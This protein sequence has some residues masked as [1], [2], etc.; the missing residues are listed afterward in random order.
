MFVQH[1]G[2]ASHHRHRNDH[3]RRQ[4]S[5]EFQASPN[6][7]RDLGQIQPPAMDKRPPSRFFNFV[8]Q[9]KYDRKTNNNKNKKQFYYYYFLFFI[10]QYILYYI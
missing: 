7:G 6:H 10:L 5:T 1:G 4:M 8:Y 3:E 9:I 2:I